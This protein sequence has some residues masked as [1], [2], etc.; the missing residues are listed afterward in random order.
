[1]IIKSNV[2]GRGGLE[3]TSSHRNSKFTGWN[4]AENVGFFRTIHPPGGTLTMGHILWIVRFS[5]RVAACNSTSAHPILHTLDLPLSFYRPLCY[6]SRAHC[7]LL[8]CLSTIIPT[9]VYIYKCVCVCVCVCRTSSIKSDSRFL[10]FIFYLSNFAEIFNFF[11]TIRL[12]E[13]GIFIR[14]KYNK[15]HISVIITIF[16]SS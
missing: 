12:A 15:S 4:L 8:Q 6:N 3:V 16:L 9:L 14:R 13:T 1:M 10:P 2:T 7:P 11:F 5:M